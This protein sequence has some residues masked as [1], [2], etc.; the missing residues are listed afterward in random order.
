MCAELSAVANDLAVGKLGRLKKSESIRFEET[1]VLM[2]AGI[3]VDLLN[4]H[5]SRLAVHGRA[6]RTW[7]GGWKGWR[8]EEETDAGNN[9][10][11]I[12]Y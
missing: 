7:I 6:E 3:L 9:S 12:C 1:H 4:I 11:D 10:P 2:N 8:T 5:R